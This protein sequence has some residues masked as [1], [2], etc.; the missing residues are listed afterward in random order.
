MAISLLALRMVVDNIFQNSYKLFFSVPEQVAAAQEKI[1]TVI[2]KLL[3]PEGFSG[4]ISFLESGLDAV[5]ANLR[6]RKKT[7]ASFYSV[8]SAVQ[9]LFPNP[10]H[11]RARA[12]LARKH[13]YDG[14]LDT[15][16]K[17]GAQ[18][19]GTFNLPEGKLNYYQTSEPWKQADYLDTE[20]RAQLFHIA[21]QSRKSPSKK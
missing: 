21:Q 13:N 11:P 3:D 16:V 1:G 5:N 12:L 2:T 8:S 17:T 7:K 19:A 14:K 6:N 4:R 9:S 18:I 20:I 15:L 10:E